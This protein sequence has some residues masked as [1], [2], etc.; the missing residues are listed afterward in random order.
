M[1]K[2]AGCSIGGTFAL[3]GFIGITVI[4]LTWYPKLSLPLR[5]SGFAATQKRMMI[6]LQFTTLT[7]T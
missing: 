6:I 2:I 7:L 3:G 4:D 1:A 5:P